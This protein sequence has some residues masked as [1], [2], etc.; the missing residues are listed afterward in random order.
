MRRAGWI[1]TGVVGWSLF[2]GLLAAV[3]QPPDVLCAGVGLVR[4]Y[5]QDW[6]PSC[7]RQ[8][9]E[10]N[11]GFRRDE[12]GILLV[13]WVGGLIVAAVSAARD[14]RNASRPSQAT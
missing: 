12:D 8:I 14:I 11:A 2:V 9:A 6:T 1:V 5:G 3:V 7:D 13:L 10:F 4:P